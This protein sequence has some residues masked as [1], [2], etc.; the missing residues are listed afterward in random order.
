VCKQGDK[1]LTSCR[2]SAA[3]GSGGA[4]LPDEEGSSEEDDDEDIYYSWAAVYVPPVAEYFG[5][6]SSQ[7]AAAVA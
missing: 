1:G 3:G 5:Y 6:G 2:C 7:G 4:G